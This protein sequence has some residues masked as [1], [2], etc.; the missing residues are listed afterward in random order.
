MDLDNNHNNVDSIIGDDDI[1]FSSS[2]NEESSE[3]INIIDDE[4]IIDDD[5]NSNVI[6]Q[7]DNGDNIDNEFYEDS[8]ITRGIPEGYNDYY[9]YSDDDYV[10]TFSDEDYHFINNDELDIERSLPESDDGDDVIFNNLHDNQWIDDENIITNNV[11]EDD[12]VH[13][14]AFCHYNSP[15]KAESDYFYSLQHPYHKNE[16][17]KI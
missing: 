15:H 10:N 14:E 13:E 16:G 17:K 5:Q 8:V 1:I 6:I 2:H 12:E 4:D 7:D 11:N 9:S 3:E